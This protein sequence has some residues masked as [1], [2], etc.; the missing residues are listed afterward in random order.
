MFIMSENFL[1]LGGIK[2][3][4]L[5][6]NALLIIL[7]ISYVFYVKNS[8]LFLF[9]NSKNFTFKKSNTCGICFNCSEIISKC[10]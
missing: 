10:D 6:L 7:A 1:D 4:L 8:K 3:S 9:E 2:K 5:I